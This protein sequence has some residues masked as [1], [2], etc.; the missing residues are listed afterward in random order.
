MAIK[1]AGTEVISDTQTIKVTG[2]GGTYKGYNSGGST[3]TQ[4]AGN[5]KPSY[6]VAA[7]N[8]GAG[9]SPISFSQSAEGLGA[10]AVWWGSGGQLGG[11]ITWQIQGTT[12]A[13]GMMRTL[14][15][16]ATANGYD[17]SFTFPNGTILYPEDTEPD[18][19]T[20]RYWVHYLTA[21]DASTVSVVS[22]S[23]SAA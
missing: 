3:P 13:S 15:V 1:V 4:H 6:V 2:G 16:D 18:F 20:A 12:L 10:G 19:A 9:T 21:W 17:Q 11:T 23:W 8:P 5:I 22:T 7:S 14:W